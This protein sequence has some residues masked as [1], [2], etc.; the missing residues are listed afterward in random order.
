MHTRAT[1]VQASPDR[2]EQL[3]TNFKEKVIPYAK[4]AKG[5]VGAALLYDREKGLAT[6]ITIWESARALVESEELGVATRTQAAASAAA[7]IVNV[8]RGEV[9]VMDRAGPVQASGFARTTFGYADPDKID[10]VVGLIRDKAVPLLRQQKGYRAT[11]MTI[12][13][14]TG[15][16]TAMTIWDSADDREASNGAI[17]P[18]REEAG[19][20]MGSNVRVELSEQLVAELVAPVAAR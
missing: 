13:R 8:E 6:G 14:T 3:T 10:Q 7:Q 4:K 20:L 1:W 5:F 12:D 19:R 17:S 16:T 2:V 11:W 18:L 15:Q 9:V